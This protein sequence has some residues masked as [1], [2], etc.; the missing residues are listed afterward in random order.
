MGPSLN[1]FQTPNMYMSSFRSLVQKINGLSW[2]PFLAFSALMPT[3]RGVPMWSNFWGLKI[4][5]GIRYSM[6]KSKFHFF[7][8]C[9]GVKVDIG[10]Y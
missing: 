3:D 5:L 1:G 7:V 10:K 9:F 2:V 4:I 8:W 6:L